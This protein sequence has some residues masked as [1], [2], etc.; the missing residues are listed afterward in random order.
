[1]S[2]PDLGVVIAAWLNQP[3]VKLMSSDTLGGLWARYGTPFPFAPNGQ[4]SLAA[5]IKRNLDVKIS[6][7]SLTFQ[8]TLQQLETMT[9]VDR[10]PAVNPGPDIQTPRSVVSPATQQDPEPAVPGVGAQGARNG[11][12]A[13]S[14]QSGNAGLLVTLGRIA[15]IGGISVGA[16]FLLLEKLQFV[17]LPATSGTAFMFLCYGVAVIGLIVWASRPNSNLWLPAILGIV[18]LALG[19]ISFL[20][21]HPPGH[22]SDDR[23]YTIHVTATSPDGTLARSAL[24]YSTMGGEKLNAEAGGV[25]HITASPNTHLTVFAEVA[26]Q[27]LSGNEEIVLG[28]DHDFAPPTIPLTINGEPTIHGMVTN[29]QGLGVPDAMVNV[30]GYP[31]VHTDAGGNFELPSHAHLRDHVQIHAQYPPD[32]VADVPDYIVGSA[33][34]PLRLAPVN[35]PPVAPAI[36]TSYTY[37]YTGNGFP[38][39]EMEFIKNSNDVWLEKPSPASPRQCLAGTKQFSFKETESNPQ[40]IVLFDASRE[41]Y[42]R[43]DRTKVGVESSAMFRR[44]GETT[45]AAI[46]QVTRG[47]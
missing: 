46:H 7:S 12:N 47:N 3:S 22:P 36:G 24:F 11:G 25:F 45:W 34:P 14:D 5:E 32:L 31:A 1:M 41:V 18:A 28:A 37:L 15:G 17:Q 27:G 40:Y 10:D 16:F 35:A 39:C 23:A 21:L 2:N 43:L 33:L 6:I 38:Q 26:N 8:L 29:S 20:A 30:V 42:I 19:W 44:S 13:K 9:S 4:I